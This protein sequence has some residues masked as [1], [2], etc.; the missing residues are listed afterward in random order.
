MITIDGNYQE[1]GGQIVR[2][3]LA[4]STITGKPFIVQD[5]RKGRKEGGLK[6]QHLHCIKTLQHFC[7]AQVQGAFL[8]SER[9]VFIPNVLHTK[10]LNIDIGTAGSI[11]LLMQ[12]L[13][14]PIFQGRQKIALSITGGTDVPFSQ[15]IDYF[16]HVFLPCIQNF[17]DV[18]SEL[19][20]RGFYPKG[21]GNIS[22]LIEPKRNPEPFDLVMHD[23]ILGIKG[24]SFASDDLK[25]VDVAER[26]TNAAKH[27]LESIAEVNIQ[28]VYGKT[29]S[30][31]S[32]IVL[33]A[34]YA[35]TKIGADALGERGKSA[36]HVA[37]EAAKKLSDE[38]QEGAVI[39]S[40][41]TDSLIPFL[42]LVGG[43]IKTSKITKHTLANIYVTK[44]FLDVHFEIKEN[45]ITATLNH[46]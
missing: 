25:S 16:M 12:S 43:S 28:T 26:Q 27:L 15:P 45:M 9:L 24:I 8:G 39:D 4:L 10:D 32:V 2:T 21:Q 14:L 3:A 13:L 33:W 19:H 11:T 31:G 7:D 18:H 22:F 46:L 29:Q 20:Q 37:K 30:P 42:G 38:I 23:E 40:N 35:D 5:I 44:K 1:G 41:C 34:E 17:V 36:E 6:N